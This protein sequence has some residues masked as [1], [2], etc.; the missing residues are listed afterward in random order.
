MKFVL[1]RLYA[2]KFKQLSEVE[3]KFPERG[4]IL[5]EGRNEAGK[6]T[7]F[8]A[9]Y[10]ALYG[11]TFMEKQKLEDL[12]QYGADEMRVEL[13][14]AVGNR[15]FHI[16]R[17]LGGNHR[18]RM[19]YKDADGNAQ[20]SNNLTDVGRLIPAELSLSRDALL[21][22]CFV[23]QKDLGRLEALGKPERESAI[24]ELLNLKTLTYLMETFDIKNGERDAVK[25]QRVRVEIAEWDADLPELETAAKDAGRRV[26]YSAALSRD[27]ERKT[28]TQ[29]AD[30]A[31]TTKNEKAARRIEI[32][33]ILETV[34]ALKAQLIAL[35]SDLSH[36]VSAWHNA[37]IQRDAAQTNVTRLENLALALPE[38]QTFLDA[39]QALAGRLLTLEKLESDAAELERNRNE[40]A[41][42]IRAYEE[43]L[44][45]WKTGKID[46]SN[47]ETE[48]TARTKTL[49][50]AEENSAA[51]RKIRE[52]L[53]QL[54]LLLQHSSAQVL[55]TSEAEAKEKEC[56]SARES[57]ALWPKLEARQK[58]LETAEKEIRLRDDTNDSITRKAAELEERKRRGKDHAGR[59]E[60]LI[61]LSDKVTTCE[62]AL[63]NAQTAETAAKRQSDGVEVRL[64]LTDWADAAERAAQSNPQS[65]NIA[66]LETERTTAE[67]AKTNAEA[68]EKAAARQMMMGYAAF[69]VAGIMAAAGAGLHLFVLFTGAIVSLSGGAIP[70]SQGM[71]NRKIAQSEIEEA[72]QKSATLAG[73]IQQA[74]KQIASFAAEKETRTA[75]E[76]AAR[77]HLETLGAVV[78]ANVEAARNKAAEL[79]TP[80]R[81]D[82]NAA[83][84]NAITARHGAES[85]LTIAKN[86][87]DAEQSA[88]SA[89]DAGVMDAKIAELTAE[90]TRLQD[91]LDSLSGLPALCLALN[92][93]EDLAA[94]AAE[95]AR[96][97]ND[98][99]REKANA[100][101]LPDLKTQ[102]AEKQK[103]AQEEADAALALAAALNLPGT[104][105]SEITNAATAEQTA[106]L[107]EI[108]ARPDAAIEAERFAAQ[109]EKDAAQTALTTLRETQRQRQNALNAMN[110]AQMD[111]EQTEIGN[112]LIENQ[113]KQAGFA[114][115]R[116]TLQE[117]E[118]P[119]KYNE[120]Q[121]Q[122]AALEA[123]LNH[124][125][126][127]I[128]KLADAK[129]VLTDC[130]NALREKAAAFGEAWAKILPKEETPQNLAAAQTRL[131]QV[132]E[133]KNGLLHGHCEAARRDEDAALAAEMKAL[134]TTITTRR[135]QAEEARKQVNRLLNELGAEPDAALEILPTQRPELAAVLQNAQ[136]AEAWAQEKTIADEAVHHNRQNRIGTARAHS[137]EETAL[138]LNEEKQE[139]AKLERGLAVRTQAGAILKQARQAIIHSV[140]PLTMNNMNRLLP[141]LTEGRYQQAQWAD[142]EN[143][144]TVYDNQKRDYQ[145]KS[146]FSGGAKDQISLALRLSFAMATLPGAHSVRPAWLFLDEPLSSFDRQRTFDLVK[147]LTAPK[148]LIRGQFD[149]IFLISHSEAFD[150]GLFD[151]RLRMDGGRIIE[152]SLPV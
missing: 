141:L 130:A 32:A 19:E 107:A 5:I 97:R 53:P 48:L 1:R 83:L 140:M 96:V 64:A 69:V 144:I 58:N 91:V 143:T 138:S 139:Q 106:F 6:S 72:K 146:V 112:A 147:M 80:S 9:V 142:A 20:I 74:Q 103:R 66:A 46:E 35:D 28:H 113:N 51:R 120:L 101:R 98:A 23:A 109:T 149:Q 70:V 77:Q 90:L 102:A 49:T 56:E 45:A 17:K 50:E 34:A 126:N 79:P 105:L 61:A 30:S 111:A 87:L 134:E 63:S 122:I 114:D 59:L 150:P 136:D 100:A 75:Q 125:R 18:V 131:P 38:A 124:T 57:A 27:S 21:N 12:R 42:K 13:D 3:L 29:E 47:A 82:A 129:Q 10:F 145:R 44:K 4:T 78:P 92:V 115:V 31:E 26:T 119:E 121:S 62:T 43:L 40:I 25:R 86:A 11:N 117:M 84:Q 39:A 68:K 132:R 123:N 52:R 116:P 41:G 85:S 89:Y 108:E 152:N 148:G 67:T 104:A 76:T 15:E 60:N 118:L 65:E 54:K 95:L 8:E 7:L 33:K 137:I 16:E 94:I 37:E 71:K 2:D 81:T 133:T 127:E 99:A 36:R 14:F 22:T 151:Y 135:H 128:A 110:L 93:T 55:L 24:N 88:I 73:T